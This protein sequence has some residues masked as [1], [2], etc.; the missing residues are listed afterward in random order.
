MSCAAVPLGTWAMPCGFLV[1]LPRTRVVSPWAPLS[2][3]PSCV[4][5]LSGSPGAVE[6]AE[7]SCSCLPLPSPSWFSNPESRRNIIFPCSSR[8]PPG[9]T[10]KGRLRMQPHPQAP[11]DLA[12]GSH[13]LSKIVIKR[14]VSTM[15]GMESKG[16]FPLVHGF[17][18]GVFLCTFE[19]V[20]TGALSE[21]K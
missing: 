6:E 10:G 12:P 8:P 21:G 9:G 15:Q 16:G 3:P 18:C 19:K 17:T 2:S 14:P 20:L 1:E 13:S 5:R 4:L 7:G 11:R